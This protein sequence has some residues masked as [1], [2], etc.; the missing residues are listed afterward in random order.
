MSGMI[1]PHP[2]GSNSVITDLTNS[3]VSDLV[4]MFICFLSNLVFKCMRQHV[5]KH[6][7]LSFHVDDEFFELCWFQSASDVPPSDFDIFPSVSMWTLLSLSSFGSSLICSVNH[8]ALF[9]AFVYFCCLCLA[10]WCCVFVGLVLVG[11]LRVCCREG[12]GSGVGRG[13]G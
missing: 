9:S 5:G 3:Y 4:L 10:R 12:G 11:A 6:K 7:V 8:C 13:V 1:C 2:S